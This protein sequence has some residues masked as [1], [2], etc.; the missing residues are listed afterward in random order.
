MQ[1]VCVSWLSSVSTRNLKKCAS[2][3]GCSCG[4]LPEA[5]ERWSLL[6]RTCVMILKRPPQ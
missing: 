6:W 2:C 3:H 1:I 5:L 4:D